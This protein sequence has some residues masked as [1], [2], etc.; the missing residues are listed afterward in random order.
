LRGVAEA[1]PEIPRFARNKLRNPKKDEI[2]TPFGL[3]MTMCGVKIFDAFVLSWSPISQFYPSSPFLPEGWLEPLNP[4]KENCCIH[5]SFE[6][7]LLWE[8]VIC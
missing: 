2:A 6:I 7:R 1:N 8:V 3:A 4:K 5:F